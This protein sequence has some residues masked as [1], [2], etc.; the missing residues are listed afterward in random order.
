LGNIIS[1]K[2]NR[3]VDNTLLLV[4]NWIGQP[5][6]KAWEIE[7]LEKAECV[8]DGM[9]VEAGEAAQAV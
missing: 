4:K 9:S 1:N 2:R 6:V 3:L 7:E 8:D 5:D